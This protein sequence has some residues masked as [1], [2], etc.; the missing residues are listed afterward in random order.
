MKISVHNKTLVLFL[1]QLFSL[2]VSKACHFKHNIISDPSKLLHS[3]S[4]SSDCCSAWEGVACDPSGRV[5]N[6]SRP[7]IVW[8]SDFLFDTYMSGTLSWQLIDLKGPIPPK[9]GELSHHTHLFLDSNKLFGSIPTTFRYLFKL[10]KLYIGNNYISGVVPSSVFGSLSSLLELGLSGNRLSGPIPT[11]IGKLVL[12]TKLDLHGNNI[13]GSIPVSTGKL[14]S[15]TYLD[16]S[17]N[18]IIGR[19]PQSIGALSQLVLLYLNHNQLNGSIPSSI[20]GLNSPRFCQLSQNKLAGALPASLGQLPKIERL[21]FKNNKLSGKFLEGTLQ[22]SLTFS[23]PTIVLQARFLQVFSNLLNLQTLDLLTNRFIG[24]IPSQLAK[25]QRLD[26]L[27][28]SFNPLGLVSVPSFF[29]RL[30]LFRLLLE[31]TGIEGQ[32]PSWLSSSYVSIFDLSSNSWTGK[33]PHRIGNMTSLSFMN[34]SNNGF[35][36]SILAEFRNLS[37]LMDLDLHLNKFTGPIHEDTM[38]DVKKLTA[39]F[40]SSNNLKT[41]RSSGKIPPRKASIPVS[42][43]I[44]NPGLCGA[45]LPPCNHF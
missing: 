30:K 32:L 19:L 28:L 23:S 4:L 35:Q 38:G 29:A 34:L 31:R 18:R 9:F 26:T 1:S 37:L 2:L 40:L 24:Q 43:F 22:F 42:G 8:G 39:L 13:S 45:P 14:K 10:E 44:D 12:L 11:S 25:L 6:L 21:I 27:D 41:I 20:S 17:G 15:L 3:W 36:S 33:L 16:L 5:V 7:G